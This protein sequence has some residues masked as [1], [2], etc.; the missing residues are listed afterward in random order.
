MRALKRGATWRTSPGGNGLTVANMSSCH[1]AQF[2]RV[3][4]VNVH[5]IMINLLLLWTAEAADV[6]PVRE[7][8]RLVVWHVI[9]G[10]GRQNI[11]ALF[12]IHAHSFIIITVI[13]PCVRTE[14][15]LTRFRESPL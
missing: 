7:N 4:F 13:T 12:S 10:G 15:S 14:P 6:L 8:E 11:T 5:L 1:V 9:E 2:D 3:D